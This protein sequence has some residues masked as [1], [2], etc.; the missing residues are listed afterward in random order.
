MM[1]QPAVENMHSHHLSFSV[2]LMMMMMMVLQPATRYTR[3]S[4]TLHTHH[5]SPFLY[6]DTLTCY[7]LIPS[8]CTLWYA[9][10]PSSGTP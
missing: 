5:I 4:C 9:L 8:L 2:T 6:P 7:T 1:L 3:R 10:I